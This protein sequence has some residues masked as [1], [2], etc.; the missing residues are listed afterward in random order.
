MQLL[1]QGKS[2]KSQEILNLA[3]SGN[4]VSYVKYAFIKI[5]FIK[6]VLIL[7]SNHYLIII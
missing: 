7:V 2:W 4:P 1:S 5:H 6:S 3:Y